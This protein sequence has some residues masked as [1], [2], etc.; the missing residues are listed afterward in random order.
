M[1]DF[2][3][4]CGQTL[5]GQNQVPGQTIVCKYCGRDLGMGEKVEEKVIV[6]QAQEILQSGAAVRC[7]VCQQLVQVKVAGGI[8][9]LVPHAGQGEKRRM[10]PGGGKPVVEPARQAPVE[11]PRL[12]PKPGRK[13]LSAYM[14]REQIRVVACRRN[15]EPTIE[16]LRLEYL[17][18]A[19]RVRLQ[20]EA[21]RDI[22]GP[23]F[24]M[25]PYPAEL[26]R[27]HLA[28]W[29]NADCCVVAKKRDQGG[30]DPMEQE[31]L[32]LVVADVRQ[33]QH[34]FLG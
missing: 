9:S 16:E 12:Q 20:I 34:S 25:K 32:L 22:L 5:G 27:P 11:T 1:F 2:C 10:C 28:V 23:A 14:N 24:R 19:D 29:A 30:Y 18:K 33:R 6:D 3:P 8:R 4:H 26:K 17:D 21:L 7:P 31:E 13:D 15:V